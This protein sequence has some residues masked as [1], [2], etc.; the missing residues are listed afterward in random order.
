MDYSENLAEEDYNPV[1]NQK[2]VLTFI[3][4]VSTWG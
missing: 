2:S 1:L 3:F 4:G